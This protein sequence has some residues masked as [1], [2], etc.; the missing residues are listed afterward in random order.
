[1]SHRKLDDL[2]DRIL[3][4]AIANPERVDELKHALRAKIASRDRSV[5]YSPRRAATPRPEARQVWR[6][7]G[8]ADLSDD[9]LWDNVPV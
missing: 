4:A 1:M 8:L 2:I 9:S 3:D 6:G 5:P 7:T